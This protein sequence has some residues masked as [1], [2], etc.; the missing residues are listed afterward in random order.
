[1]SV[2]DSLIIGHGVYSVSEAARYARLKISS[3]ERWVFGYRDYPRIVNPDFP[4]MNGDRA[5][6]F[7]GLVELCLMSRFKSHGLGAAKFREAAD[8]LTEERG[9]LHPFA[10][11]Y[12]R[13]DGQDFFIESA[14]DYLQLTGKQRDNMVWR[15]IV[16]PFFREVDFE[17]TYARRW[18]PPECGKQV[19]LDPMVKFGDPVIAGTRIPTANIVEQVAAGDSP[20]LIASAYD[21]SIRQVNAARR[22][23]ERYPRA[24]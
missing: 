22:F 4:K 24:A 12:L 17:E 6:S 23:E 8:R 11:Q 13:T 2:E 5:I 3:V 18:Y 16:E 1:M 7:L 21:L 19:V 14:D 20:A 15:E 10:F 9:V